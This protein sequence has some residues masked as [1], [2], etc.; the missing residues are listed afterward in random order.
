M[1]EAE[2]ELAMLKDVLEKMQLGQ[3]DLQSKVDGKKK[4]KKKKKDGKSPSSSGKKDKKKKKKKDKKKEKKK[5]G[6]GSS[7]SESSSSSPSSGSSFSSDEEKICRWAV[8]SDGRKRKI[9]QAQ[10]L[11]LQTMRFKKRGDLLTFATRYPGALVMHF[12]SQARAKAGLGTARTCGEMVETD[13]ARWADN[14]GL[15]EVRDRKEVEFLAKLITTIGTKRIAEAMDLMAM[16]IR[17]V[18]LAKREGQS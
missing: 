6:I 4:K 9:S 14:S 2:A 10:M 17:E 3:A 13:L 11:R 16:R 12:M 1:D 18:L 7:D 8:T 15:K 5:F